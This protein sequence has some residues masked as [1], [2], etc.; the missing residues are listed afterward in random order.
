MQGGGGGQ[1]LSGGFQAGSFTLC[2]DFLF[3]VLALAILSEPKM[4]LKIMRRAWGE[5][6]P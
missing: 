1:A 2:W 5:G 4:T 6:E 3:P